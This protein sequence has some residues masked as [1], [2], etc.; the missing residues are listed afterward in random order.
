MK[1]LIRC[2]AFLLIA[3]LIF[4]SLD[5]LLVRK[6]LYGW[7]N[8]T[9][10]TNGFFNS[11]HD[12]Y[13][14]IFCGSSH[15][16]CSFNPLVIGEE[17][18][19]SSYTIATQKQPLWA[20]YYYISEAIERQNP[21]LVV[22]DTFAFSLTDEYS[23]E[24]TSFTYTDDFPFGMNKL[25]MVYHSAPKG[26]RFNLMFRFGKYHSRWSELSAEDFSYNPKELFDYLYGYCM[27]TATDS[28][29][30]K[31]DTKNAVTLPSSDKNELWLKK[32]IELCKANDIE[33]L[34]VKTPS[35]ETVEERG[36]FNRAEEIAEGN[37]VSFI[38][39]NDLYEEIGLNLST[40]FF[41][42]A[43]LNH[44]G[45]DKF[46]RYFAKTALSGISL[47]GELDESFYTR[48][49]RYKREFSGDKNIFVCSSYIFNNI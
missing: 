26:E 46:S 43:H 16:Y 22:L 23:D 6:S 4:T 19:L 28:T 41:D 29:V 1:K 7:W 9:T 32:I 38:N 49:A 18:G 8:I 39:Y 25:K 10:K 40:D 15:A 12:I 3:T 20:T 2:V 45:A 30:T 5:K 14:V 37:G 21:S 35:N 24:A 44:I 36:Y 47:K 13:D 31:P 27:L 11:D 48:L 42:R 33:L 34:I 17:T